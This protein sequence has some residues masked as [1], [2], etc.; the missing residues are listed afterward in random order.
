MNKYIP[1]KYRKLKF[2]W[3]KKK[4]QKS[5]E[6]NNVSPAGILPDFD[7]GYSYNLPKTFILADDVANDRTVKFNK[8]RKDT[9]LYNG[10][11][12]I[13][14][15]DGYLTTDGKEVYQQLYNQRTKEEV[16]RDYD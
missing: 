11:E 13:K 1:K 9:I 12:Y 10:V 8:E 7:L 15:T 3:A 2:P 14:M 6:Q 4:I 16:K 5:S